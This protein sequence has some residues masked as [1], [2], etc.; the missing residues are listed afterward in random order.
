M[1]VNRKIKISLII[2]L[3]FVNNM[4]MNV[5]GFVKILKA[6]IGAR[7]CLTIRRKTKL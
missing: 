1:I 3:S 4:T 5:Y 7:K 6:F 2:L